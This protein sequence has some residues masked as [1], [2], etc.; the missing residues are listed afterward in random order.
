MPALSEVLGSTIPSSPSNTGDTAFPD[1]DQFNRFP[2]RGRSAPNLVL[3]MESIPAP[4]LDRLDHPVR[5]SGSM[6]ASN[7]EAYPDPGQDADDPL[8][9][10]ASNSEGILDHGQDTDNPLPSLEDANVAQPGDTAEHYVPWLGH[11]QKNAGLIPM[12]LLWFGPV[13]TGSMVLLISHL[14]L[15]VGM[16]FGGV[17]RTRSWGVAMEVLTDLFFNAYFALINWFPILLCGQFL[18]LYPKSNRL[19]SRMLIV[20]AACLFVFFSWAYC[21]IVSTEKEGPVVNFG[22]RQHLQ[23][24]STGLMPQSFKGCD[25]RVEPEQASLFNTD[26]YY[27]QFT[28]MWYNAGNNTHYNIIYTPSDMERFR[29]IQAN[30]TLCGQGFEGNSDLYGLGIRISLYLQWL[31]SLLT[32]NFLPETRQQIQN[33]YLVSSFAVCLATIVASFVKTCVFSIEI[34]I[35]YWMYWGGYICVFGS[36]PC[37]VRL[38]SAMKWIKLDWTTMILFTTHAL[39]IYD[40]AWFVCYAY[41]QVFSRMPCGTYHFFFYPILDPSQGFWTLRDYVNH[42]LGFFIPALVILFPFVGLVSAAEV[43]DTVQHSAIFEFLFP[44][45]TISDRNQPQTTE[46]NASVKTSPGLGNNLFIA[47]PYRKFRGMLNLPS[48]SRGG[49]RLVT[50]IDIRD[51][52]FVAFIDHNILRSADCC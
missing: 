2:K 16:L 32:N 33:L 26:I 38:G 1:A 34:E 27:V 11:N 30:Q 51:R 44:K 7:P 19:T 31:S 52:R 36:A 39:M 24:W 37:P 3:C 6:S 8:P 48:H 40:G 21:A 42:M 17:I 49:I 25:A 28:R 4:L 22:L 13:S 41:D 10:S 15:S 20:V 9:M 14:C 43:K 29:S 47:R 23:T 35:L 12:L 18:V 5:T 45:A 46:Q 50:P